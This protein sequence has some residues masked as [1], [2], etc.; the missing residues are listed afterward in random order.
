MVFVGLVDVFY[1][2]VFCYDCIWNVIMCVFVMLFV[3]FIMRCVV[4][5]VLR[6]VGSGCMCS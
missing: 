5:K 6:F 3:C 2:S 1:V 4:V